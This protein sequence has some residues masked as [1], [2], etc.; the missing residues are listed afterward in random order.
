MA[1]LGWRLRERSCVP[2]MYDILRAMISYRL[3]TLLISNLTQI[4][5]RTNSISQFF[6]LPESM[7]IIFLGFVCK[8]NSVCTTFKLLE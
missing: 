6:F 1:M 8:T 5:I 4:S 7:H 3:S 2:V